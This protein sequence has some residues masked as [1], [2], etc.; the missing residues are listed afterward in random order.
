MNESKWLVNCDWLTLN[1]Q[2]TIACSVEEITKVLSN[3]FVVKVLPYGTRHFKYI[4]D[5][6]YSEG[7]E[8]ESALQIVCVPLSKILHPCLVQVK[9]ANIALYNRKA[10]YYISLFERVMKCKY[11]GVSRV[12]VCVDSTFQNIKE[13]AEGLKNRTIVMK[14]RKKVQEYYTIDKCK[15]VEYE[16]IKFGSAVSAYTFKIY[17]KTKEINEESLK[18][19]IIDYWKE[20]GFADDDIVWRYE[21]SIMDLD[22][23]VWADGEEFDGRKIL[24]DSGRLIELLLYYAKKIECVKI[25]K[26]AIECSVKKYI[27][28]DREEEYLIIPKAEYIEIP[29]KTESK[30]LGN[31]TKTAKACISM[32]LGHILTGDLNKYEAYNLL[33]AIF[34]TAN[35]LHLNEWLRDRKFDEIRDCYKLYDFTD[36]RTGSVIIQD[37]FGEDWVLSRKTIYSES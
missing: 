33:Q 16:G 18:Y 27:R 3:E 36:I 34:V 2:T 23:I 8:I 12:D 19:Y 15:G 6:S 25:E 17:N 21:F 7:W 10:S 4:I 20:N 35:Q 11:L 1:Y 5:L 32:N 14:G 24:R 9:V 31:K 30:R 37:L 28:F 29:I 13:L 26:N 22:K